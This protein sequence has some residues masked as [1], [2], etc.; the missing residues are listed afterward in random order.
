MIENECPICLEQLESGLKTPCG[1]Q[2]CTHCL[3]GWQEKETNSPSSPPYTCP[4]CRGEIPYIE[5]ESFS[6]NSDNEMSDFESHDENNMYT[7]TARSD[8]SDGSN[9][10]LSTNS[11]LKTEHGSIYYGGGCNDSK[12]VLD[13]GHAVALVGWGQS[14]ELET[15]ALKL[16]WINPAVKKTIE[17]AG[18]SLKNFWIVRNSWG[19]NWTS[20]GKAGGGYY[21]TAMYPVNPYAQ[22]VILVNLICLRFFSF[23]IITRRPE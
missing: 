5:L 13:G 3:V 10:T 11:W 18:G 1:H 2:F 23:L 15:A 19:T 20:G 9:V 21:L 12:T 14:D 8:S 16:P 17:D 6:S 7:Q 4:S 22:T